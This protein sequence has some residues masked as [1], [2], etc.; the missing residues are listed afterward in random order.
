M[1]SNHRFQFTW[2]TKRCHTLCNILV[3]YASAARRSDDHGASYSAGPAWRCLLLLMLS[4]SAVTPLHA[5]IEPVYF[6][7][8][9]LEEGLSQSR[10]LAVEQ[11]HHGFMWFGTQD[12]LNRY[13][14]Y[15]FR[16]LR[17]KSTEGEVTQGGITAL[18]AVPGGLWVGTRRGGLYFF[19]TAQDRFIHKPLPINQDA[20]QAHITG[21]C[22][23][24]EGRLWI[25]ARP[26][27]L[28]RIDAAAYSER[29]VVRA[30]PFEHPDLKQTPF[31]QTLAWSKEGRLW[32]GTERDGLLALDTRTNQIERWTTAR[33]LASDTILCLL[34]EPD[35]TLWIGSQDGLH[36][37]NRGT[38]DVAVIQPRDG[39]PRGLSGRQVWSLLRDRHGDLW[40]GTRDDGLNRS[41]D[42]GRTFDHFT[43]SAVNPK[44]LSSNQVWRLFEDRSGVIW[45]G[46]GGQGINKFARGLSQFAR[47]DVF[48][49]HPHSPGRFVPLS[50]AVDGDERLWIGTWSHGLV[51]LD[52]AAD[53]FTYHRLDD[54]AQPR[55]ADQETTLILAVQADRDNQLW[56][57]AYRRGLLRYDPRTGRTRAVKVPFEGD[58]TPTALAA[59]GG[60]ELWVGTY[61]RGLLR[62]D[63]KSGETTVFAADTARENALSM[64]QVS[65]LLY[66]SQ[67][68]LWVATF[69]GGLNLKLPNRDGFIH[70]RNNPD[71]GDS[72]P[73]D[74][75]LTLHEDPQGRIWIGTDG[76]GLSLWRGMEK[77]FQRFGEDDGLASQVVNGIVTDV[78]GDM[79]VATNKGLN[80]R[81]ADGTRWRRFGT[82]EGVMLEF[83][84]GVLAQSPSGELFFGGTRGINRF[85]PNFIR[86]NTQ[87]PPVVLTAVKK[88]DEHAVAAPF[89]SSG[90][91]LNYTD[92]FISFEFAALDYT[93]PGKNR[94]LYKLEG[95]DAD[96][97]DA[98]TRRTA[99]YTNLDGG[100]YTFRVKAGNNDGVWNEAGLAL[101]LTIHPPFWQTWWFRLALV[102]LALLVLVA[103]PFLWQHRR[104]QRMKRLRDQ[105]LETKRRLTEG[106]EVERLRIAQEI[107]DGPVQDLHAVHIQLVLFQRGLSMKLAKLFGREAVDANPGLT[108]GLGDLVAYLQRVGQDLRDLCGQLRPPTLQHF[109]LNAALEAHVDRCREKY[110]DIRISCEAGSPT[111]GIPEET[112]LA[113]FRICQEALNNAF[114]HAKGDVISV[115]FEADAEA[116]VLEVR[117]NGLGFEPQNLVRFSREGHFGLLGISER[118][119]AIGAQLEIESQ[120]NQGTMVRVF[121]PLPMEEGLRA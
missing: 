4:A 121:A 113:L 21:L 60:D 10:V 75:V 19:D 116:L 61:R 40:V 65:A 105:E 29:A 28:F 100:Q 58:W 16:V 33:G 57:C 41:S 39:D 112:Q 81:G 45:V 99:Y 94:Y 96:W 93:L 49:D 88:F 119:E 15:Q 12:G 37:M 63:T 87:A 120:P 91:E 31:L 47:Y 26:H 55:R 46:T 54:S 32:L 80:L 104:F 30:V 114:Q 95:L 23:D 71:A 85:H 73:H 7:H 59:G 17:P 83:N 48:P 51:S 108:A 25:A 117:D 3:S 97:V 64:N 9:A 50:M 22:L 2:F 110:P 78:N 76:G 14:G 82:G 52:T 98:G 89:A 5:F 62:Y 35:G 86:E 84:A 102:S 27:G 72:L 20:G 56:V 36:R 103:L 68:R 53:R 44:S 107:H 115:T 6:D 70:F 101:P 11:D 34:P 109:G 74:L 66:D 13:D 38:G 90:L 111:A 69:G 106:R 42:N 1:K 118:A 8:L 24:G 92:N 18:Q 79:W 43:F 77:G 67:H